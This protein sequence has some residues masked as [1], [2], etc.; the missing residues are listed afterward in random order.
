MPSTRT[1]LLPSASE[2]LSYEDLLARYE[3]LQLRV[4]RFSVVEQRLVHAQ[5]ELDE[6]LGR[7]SRIHAFTSQ[8]I[9]AKSDAAF[10]TMVTEALLDVFEQEF[11]F[12][13]PMNE[14]GTLVDQPTTSLGWLDSAPD[15][16]ILEP[17][18]TSQLDR[19]LATTAAVTSAALATQP[20]GF[21]FTHL[22]W[23]RC[24][25]QS[26]RPLALI[27]TGVRKEKADFH[28]A[29]NLDRIQ[30]FQV[31]VQEVSS[32]FTNRMNNAIIADQMAHIQRSEERLKLAI[33]GSNT[34]FWDW[35][36][37]SGRVVYS[38]LWKSML[39]Y[40]ND[41]PMES[42][43][44]WENLLHPDDRE[45]SLHRAEQHLRG[46]T[47]VFENLARLRHFDGNYVWIMARGRALR[48]AEGKVYRFVGTHFDMT[49]QKALEQRL[50]EAEDLQRTARVQAEAA[51]R[52]K[53][54]F[55][56]SMSHEIRTPM[57]G[58]VGMLQL[59]RDT[60]LT[61]S[62]TALV[63]NA[64]KSATALLDVIGDILDLSKIEAG[65]I[66][67]ADEPFKP[68]VLLHEVHSLMQIRSEAKD[69]LLELQLPPSMPDWVR[70]DAGRLRQI[71]INLVGNAIKFTDKGR[72]TVNVEAEVAESLPPAANFIIR[73][74]DTGIGI[75]EEFLPHLFEPFCQND[76]STK[77]R[78][79]GTG[80][81]LAISRSLIELMGG[82]ISA[83]S[84]AG[85]GAEFSLR[86]RLPLAAA[87]STA[88]SI[89]TVLP[90]KQT[91]SGCALVVEDNSMGQTVARLMLQQFGLTVD[92]ANNGAEGAAMAASKAYAMI[93]MDCQMPVMDGFEAT[94]AIR[95]HEAEHHLPRVPIIALTANVQP[96]DVA[97]CLQSGMDDF[98]PK[99]LR[100][101][102]LAVILM[103]H[104]HAA[105]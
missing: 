64:E 28:A 52:A 68:S 51:S 10:A 31:F 32:L 20:A 78:H 3:A 13:W 43:S 85:E 63:I 24:K 105:N 49:Q 57:N 5:N 88:P 35:D 38:D 41:E 42:L 39:G 102:G 12:F 94:A 79:G 50:R 76:D 22:V 27:I 91:H 56:A 92:I 95:L 48:D 66:D 70:G 90:V 98:L 16:R 21:D 59:L 75:A 8:A 67:L 72:I 101:D 19:M 46:E 65:K 6:E 69:L 45:E 29:L 100:K 14:D 36:I 74:R 26:G 1:S 103:K 54:I 44:V 87:V 40:G 53:S 33:E 104:L 84:S 89:A 61:G 2:A 77:R 37:E 83:S 23:G 81:G 11:A 93:L 7:F 62:Q 9:H 97:S 15:F 25:D 30:S 18:L 34:G 17:W 86:V 71:V 60:P 82:T 80:L 55:V 4:T 96:S 73:V 58:V 99:P 47:E